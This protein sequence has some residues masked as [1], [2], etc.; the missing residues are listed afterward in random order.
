MKRHQSEDSRLRQ[1][2]VEEIQRYVGFSAFLPNVAIF[3]T[4]W[5]YRFQD[6][7]RQGEG[8]FVKYFQRTYFKKVGSL[9]PPCV[10]CDVVLRFVEQGAC[11]PRSVAEPRGGFQLAD[12]QDRQGRGPP[13]GRIAFIEPA[14]SAH[15]GVDLRTRRRPEHL[16]RRADEAST[17]LD[18]AAQRRFDPRREWQNH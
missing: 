17:T 7:E 8:E 15:V 11:W 6:L 16:R 4:F 2:K 13:Q 9:E 18:H 10:V 5:R 3:S 1:V 14:C 12:S